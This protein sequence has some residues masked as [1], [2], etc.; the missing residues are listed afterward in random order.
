MSSQAFIACGMYAFNHEL[1][2]AWQALFE[3][4]YPIIGADLQ[5]RSELAFDAGDSVLRDPGLF[6]GHTCGYPLMTRLQDALIPFCVPLF[7]VPGTEGKLYSSYIIVAA[8]SEIQSLRD[9]RDSIVAINSSDSNSGMNVLRYELARLRARPG[10]FSEVIIT[11]GHLHSLEAVAANRAQVAAIDCVSYQLIADQNPEL[12]ATVRAID[13]SVQTCG[14]PLVMP[15]HRYSET[16]SASCLAALNQALDNT[17]IW[18]RERLHLT[19]FEAV[20]F[21]DYQSIINCKNFAISAGY[22]ELN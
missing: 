14:L 3:F 16:H 19:G 6:I 4:L 8:D 10:Y 21:E 7:D 13:R 11:G 15:Q 5:L 17:P 9:C 20:D 18:V 2:Q 12:V 22:P 1:K